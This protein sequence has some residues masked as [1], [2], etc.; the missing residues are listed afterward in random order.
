M[1][2]IAVNPI[3]Q[4]HAL[5]DRV[6]HPGYGSRVRH[7]GKDND[8]LIAAVPA[9]E[10][11]GTHSCGDTRSHRRENFVARGVAIFVIDAFEAV[12]I[13]EQQTQVLPL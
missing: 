3:G 2:L 13:D 1:L 4:R 10:V 11:A 8:E 6:R 9:H 7:A 5:A 12:Q